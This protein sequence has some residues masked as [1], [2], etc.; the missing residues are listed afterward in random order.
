MHI[1][2]LYT[3]L[4]LIILISLS[5]TGVS[6]TEKTVQT[7]ISKTQGHERVINTREYSGNSGA[8]IFSLNNLE[9]NELKN[10][11]DRIIRVFAEIEVPVDVAVDA[12]D[13]QDKYDD[14][15]FLVAYSDAGL[16]DIS[17]DGADLMWLD[18]DTNNADNALASLKSEIETDMHY[19]NDKF[20]YAPVSCYF[21]YEMFNKYNYNALQERGF[22]I[23][24]SKES[25]E[26]TAS[27][28][29]VT[30]TGQVDNSGL[31]RLPVIAEVAYPGIEPLAEATANIDDDNSIIIK[32]IDASIKEIGIA[33]ISIEP[34]DL[35]DIKGHF[36][37]EKL[38]RLSKLVK[39]CN[40]H[41]E[42]ITFKGWQSYAA[43]YISTSKSSE[44]ILP[45]YQGGPT[46]IF[47]LDDVSK[48]WY[49]EVDK[50][51]I[52]IFKGN[53]VPLDCGVISNAGGND[54]YELPWLK[55]Y[56]EQGNVG[57]SLHGFDWDYY[58]LD[59]TKSGLSYEYIKF[60]L[61]KAR[62]NYLYY[63]GAVP[64]AV[65][66]PT[67][68]YDKA[69]YQ[70]VKDAGFKIF[71]TLSIVEPYPST[72]PVD[73][74]GKKD[75]NGMIR[76][77]TACDLCGWDSDKQ[78]FTGPYDVSELMKIPDFCKYY[79]GISAQI[80]DRVFGYMVCRELSEL[81]VAVISIHPSAFV[82]K[83]GNID[84]VK[85]QKVDAIIKWVKTFASVTTFE[86]WYNYNA[87]SNETVT[88]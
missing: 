73:F 87:L 49:E 57:I 9:E 16:I 25:G 84:R 60:K 4:V 71:S 12:P 32:K 42:I 31:Y 35:L 6:E 43:S 47:R 29:P 23:V 38:S 70:A 33:V 36:D 61:Q 15:E 85:M 39:E 7:D 19:I 55:E 78:I 62:E 59:T 20:G 64:V 8:I 17:L 86:Q 3:F 48:G 82:D 58:Q 21:P 13:S 44:R 76:I 40:H 66:V 2:R 52:E 68:F 41:G 53:G 72:V 80:T 37:S 77:P 1:H 79:E 88:M 83:D 30:W 11:I 24:S 65:T 54:S 75:L 26:F 63:Y 34:R 14:L 28:Q 45:D 56:F 67:D 5:C 22:S 69:G 18:A 46:V 81:N 51:L 74:N 50:A 27:R 10:A